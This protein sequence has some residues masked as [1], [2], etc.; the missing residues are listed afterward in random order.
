MAARFAADLF[1][2]LFG[3]ADRPARLA[4]SLFLGSLDGGVDAW[5]AREVSRD[6]VEDA[7]VAVGLHLAA[8]VGG[9]V[10]S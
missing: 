2:E 9:W 6:E 4:G 7:A 3:L 5:T 8:R 1:R 10:P